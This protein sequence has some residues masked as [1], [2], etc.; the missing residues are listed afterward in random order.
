MSAE[1]PVELRMNSCS[2]MALSSFTYL[3]YFRGNVA[4]WRGWPSE[5]SDEVMVQG[6]FMN[7]LMSSSVMLNEAADPPRALALMMR[8]PASI[9]SIFQIVPI[10]PRVLPVHSWLA[11]ISSMD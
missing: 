2:V 6:C 3:A 11:E 8:M 1:R 10:C 4:Y 5:P 7:A 9:G